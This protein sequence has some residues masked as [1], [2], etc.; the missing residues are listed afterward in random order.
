[1]L[2]GDAR[3]YISLSALNIRLRPGCAQVTQAPSVLA[4]S[5]HGGKDLAI[6]PDKQR[7][8]SFSVWSA[9]RMVAHQTVSGAVEF[10]RP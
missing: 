1:M 10:L 4:M 6:W 3:E 2:D 8:Y 7:A 9:L 5:S